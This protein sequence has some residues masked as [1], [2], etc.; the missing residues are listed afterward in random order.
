MLSIDLLKHYRQVSQGLLTVVDVETT[1]IYANRSR[2]IELSVL[3]A[4]MADGILDQ[5]TTLINPGVSIPAE[6]TRF[7]GI[8][9]AM[10]ESAPPTAEVLPAYLPNLQQG[11]LTAHNLEFDYSFLQTEYQRLDIEFHRPEDEQ[12]C[13]VQLARLLLPGLRS[14][15]LPNLVKHFQFSVGTSH[16]AEADTQACWLLAE[17]LLNDILNE[18]DAVLLRQFAQQWIPLKY[19]ARLMRC[20]PSAARSRLESAGVT[21]RIVGKGQSK[22]WM[23]QRGDVEKQVLEQSEGQQL[24]WF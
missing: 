15:S 24:S 22:T 18:T 21:G 12:L 7:T 16:R 3:H 4:T 5:H 10:V 19:A 8:S 17:R 14:R 23:Y 1:G 20:Q 11:T 6:I 13:T 2:V 9:Q